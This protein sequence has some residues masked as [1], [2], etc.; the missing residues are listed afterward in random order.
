MFMTRKFLISLLLLFGALSAHAQD[1]INIGLSVRADYQYDWN[2]DDAVDTGFRGKYLNLDVSGKIS[3]NFSYALRQRLNKAPTSDNPFNATDWV[4]L[5][6]TKSN[7]S[8]S[9]GKQVYEMGGYEYYNAPIDIYYASLFWNNIAC[10]QFGVSGSYTTNNGKHML[11]A[12]I[13]QSPYAGNSANWFGYN[14]LWRGD[15]GI[16]KSRYSV[17]F[18]EYADGKFLNHIVLGNRL[19]FGKVFLELDLYHRANLDD[20]SLFKNFSVVGKLVYD[21]SDRVSLFA[22]ATYDQ[23]RED[24]AYDMGIFPNTKFTRYGGGVEFFPIKGK[25]NVRLHL[26]TYYSHGD[27]THP[28]N[29]IRPH[30]LITDVGLTWKVSLLKR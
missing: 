2:H 17:N 19:D 7:W 11:L 16:F 1:W 6:Y 5:T 13:T 27:N 18:A 3:D 25:R 9:A 4:Y 21:V 23:N 20:Y 15:L 22:K 24:V 10:Y 29:Y 8:I 30:G 14:L 28:T 26:N 12:Q